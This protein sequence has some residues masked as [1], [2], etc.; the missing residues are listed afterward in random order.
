MVHG[1]ELL[2]LFQ[3]LVTFRTYL[4]SPKITE[5]GEQTAADKVS[6]LSLFSH[7]EAEAESVII[8]RTSV[9]QHA[10]QAFELLSRSAEAQVLTSTFK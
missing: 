2:S 7:T 3:Q 10:Y 9:P 8:T 4:S 5:L 1:L 6:G